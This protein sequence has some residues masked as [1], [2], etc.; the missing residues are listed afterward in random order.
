[1]AF[2]GQEPIR[3]KIVIANKITEQYIILPIW[4]I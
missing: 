4:E 3:S 1:M 2:K